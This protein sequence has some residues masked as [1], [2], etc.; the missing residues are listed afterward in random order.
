VVAV[1]G[2]RVFVCV[3]CFSEP[4]EK[5][6]DSAGAWWTVPGTAAMKEGVNDGKGGGPTETRQHTSNLFLFA[7]A[8]FSGLRSAFRATTILLIKS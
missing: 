6:A 8:T 1:R 2:G 7:P 3:A 5:L 4:R